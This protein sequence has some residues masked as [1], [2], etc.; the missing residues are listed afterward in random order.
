MVAGNE[1]CL[2]IVLSLLIINLT[3][4]IKS[5]IPHIVR[6]SFV[7]L[8]WV[9]ASV[10]WAQPKA[11]FSSDVREGCAP[12]TVNF[13]DLSGG[14]NLNYRWGFGNGNNSNL[15]DP[16]AIYYQPGVYEV[17]LTV[18]DPANSSNTLTKKAYI[19]V[20]SN[21]K[22][23]FKI[24][25]PSGCSPLSTTFR[26]QSTKGDTAITN[27]RWDFG[28]GT[29]K[30]GREIEFHNYTLDGKFT[31]SLELTDGHGCKDKIVKQSFVEVKK[32]PEIDFSADELYSC[33]TPFKVNFT[34]VVQPASGNYTYQWDF[35]DGNTGNTSNPSHTYTQSSIFDVKL[36]V[37]ASNGCRALLAK[38]GYIST[39][40]LNPDFSLSSKTGC[41]PFRPVLKPILK[42]DHPDIEYSW[43]FGNGQ[44]SKLKEPAVKYDKEGLYTISLKVSIKG[45]CSDQ[46]VKPGVIQVLKSPEAYFE[47]SDTFSCDVPVNFT[48]INKS[49]GAITYD[50]RYST[51]QSSSR[52]LTYRFTSFNDHSVQL[53]ATNAANCS[54][55]FTKQ[56]VM[57][58][59]KVKIIAEPP[60]GCEPFTSSFT[61]ASIA[62]DGIVR[63]SW[64]FGDG[65]TASDVQKISHTYLDSGTYTV[66]LRIITGGGCERV[67]SIT[68]RVGK[69]TNPSFTP[70]AD[71]ICNG[72]SLQFENTTKATAV[73]DR[74]SWQI[75]GNQFSP[76]SNGVLAQRLDTGWHDVS[77]ISFNNGCQDTFILEKQVYVLPP[78]AGFEY[79]QD[80]CDQSLLRV[81]NRSTLSQNSA[82]TWF[83]AGSTFFGKNSLEVTLP[84]GSHNLRLWVRDTVFKCQDIKDTTIEVNKIMKVDFGIPKSGCA[85]AT[86]VLKN[87][88]QG[89]LIFRWDL[90]NADSSK[91]K[92]PKTIYSSSGKYS[93]QLIG[94]DRLQPTCK[95]TVQKQMDISGPS[96]EGSVV[97]NFQCPPL[98]IRMKSDA[99][100]EDFEELY[101]L[102][103][104]PAGER[105]RQVFSPGEITDTLWSPG[106]AP[107]GSWQISLVG[108]DSNGCV[109]RKDFSQT[110]KGLTTAG[111]RIGQFAE[112]TGLKYTFAV[113]LPPAADANKMK[114]EWDF[115]DGNSNNLIAQTYSFS[116]SGIYPVQLKMTDSLGCKS[117][118]FDTID[119]ESRKIHASLAA[120]KTETECPPFLVSFF[121]Q[122]DALGRRIV[123]Y[124]WDFGDG[125]RSNLR[126]PQHNY[127]MAGK[128]SVRLKVVDEWGCEDSIV[129]KD[130]ILVDGPEG[131]YAFDRKEGCVPLTVN[132]N[133]V[134][135]GASAMEWDMGDGNVIRDKL[136]YSHVYRD[137]GRYIPLLIL[138]DSFGCT[139]TLP[140]I[141]T[142]YVR[143]FPEP[144]LQFSRPCVGQ[145][146]SFV[147]VT[148]NF[149]GAAMQ[150]SW[151]FGDGTIS[152]ECNPVHVYQNGGNYLVRLEV[153]NEFGCKRSIDTLVRIRK[154]QANF[155]TESGFACVGRKLRLVDRSVSDTVIIG[156]WWTFD[157]LT[158]D[159]AG[160]IERTYDKVGPVQIQLVVL[161]AL[162]CYDTLLSS[163]NLVIGDTLRPPAADALRITVESDYAV[164]F[165]HKPSSIKDFKSYH[166]FLGSNAIFDSI[167]SSDLNTSTTYVAQG[168]NTL[169]Q[170]YCMYVQVENAC[171]M[172]AAADS[173]QVHCSVNVEAKGDTNAAIV[174]WN[175]YQGWDDVLQYDVWREQ[176]GNYG[177][178]DFLATVPGDS[179][180]YIDSSIHCHAE[181][182]YRILAVEQ[183]G[184]LQQSQ[185]DT[186]HA[187]PIW[188]N[189]IPL[190]E[191]RVATVRLDEYNRIFWDSTPNPKV[192]IVKY[193]LQ[194]SLDGVRWSQ[195]EQSEFL[196]DD[197][198]F[199]DRLVRVD[200]HF[201]IYRVRAYDT[202]GDISGWSN[203]GQ[204]ILLKAD[205]T[206]TD[207][208]FVHW[209]HYR[210]W[211]QGITRYEVQRVEPDGSF[212]H[213]GNV[214]PQDSIFID[215]ISDWNERPSYC[216]RVLAYRK[217]QQ[218]GEEQ[219]I[220]I[221]NEDCAP[222]R[223]RIYVPNAF[224]PN[225]DGLNETF[226]IKGMYVKDYRI[227]IYNR[228]GEQLF[229]SYSM[230]D[231]WDGMFDGE[232][233][234]MDVY[235]Y[236][237]ESIGVD[238][239]KRN[240]E[241]NVHLVK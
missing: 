48:F 173:L 69:K 21:P 39:E 207:R 123:R 81:Y 63:R 213:L 76:D 229:E 90:G 25:I 87:Q 205:T 33:Q 84:K 93:V 31:V 220:S 109:G 168:L 22:A 163:R 158:V 237:I 225:G 29:V 196:P 239:V 16:Q 112:C 102:I 222:V 9:V 114:F 96:V 64:D 67:D 135:K 199:D 200:D 232:M 120:D 115:G 75:D 5:P 150:C 38:T 206:N 43:D 198:E 100:P 42:F 62:Y 51:G 195:P 107:D 241:G 110:V 160:T 56:I 151:D 170:V 184:N 30:D 141:D 32:S 15:K 231:S 162:G 80:S 113:R 216:Y 219:V 77:L 134:T 164:R 204:T 127:V 19:R 165:D 132:Y 66:K 201:S 7:F 176:L 169:H 214:G 61:D 146:T 17:S 13:K 54:D 106:F 210:D 103:G 148:P 97:G 6:S 36:T 152:N 218:S 121:D 235:I 212:I 3:L 193:E 105:K 53:I 171:G 130:L 228:W 234:Q 203:E 58:D 34:S 45:K 209:T 136:T 60:E 197:R 89:D 10:A 149:S 175:A 52:D 65:D 44:T 161:D 88:S 144:A 182:R 70:R 86:V 238:G 37:S 188:Y 57:R 211:W 79:E 124:E 178:Y 194:K 131:N 190:N 191:L 83:V 8:A 166:Y 47:G 122:S 78:M 221:S 82:W 147:N 224:T 40:A 138:S 159:T 85:P 128:F 143:P 217:I 227:R 74:W 59:P 187:I 240:F 202:C 1:C 95:D 73:V 155:G 91:L 18:T 145:P 108:V 71:T 35:G 2:A 154:T 41:I 99:N 156:R 223:S 174:H 186:A 129:Y 226:R 177:S 27:W 4:P 24:D 230:N 179:L 20:F 180:N 28:D 118:Y 181:H 137:T 12:L 46:G 50:W 104:G 98:P 14:S 142:I 101:W 72:E 215:E 172:R 94:I 55:T 26:D 183:G 189:L 153:T 133:A 111:M 11:D 126:N 157:D 233:S 140:P 117:T 23:A 236:I 139:Y 167:G 92:D 68:I 208:P 119:V 125:S 185:S 192:P 116:K 49:T